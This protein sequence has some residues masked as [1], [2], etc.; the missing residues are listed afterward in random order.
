MDW[1]V[2]RWYQKWYV[3]RPSWL[4][5]HEKSCIAV[6]LLL[7][8]RTRYMF[9][10][11]ATVLNLCCH[12]I[13]KNSETISPSGF[14]NDWKTISE[15]SC[16]VFLWSLQKGKPMQKHITRD[17]FTP[18]YTNQ[19]CKTA[20]SSHSGQNITH[21]IK[22]CV[23]SRYMSR[24]TKQIVLHIKGRRFRPSYFNNRYSFT[25]QRT[26]LYCESPLG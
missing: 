2:C 16:I 3:F 19:G 14:N 6:I 25:G 18:A 7:T 5:N 23:L 22:Y 13:L 8:N 21:V 1:K 12:K 9:Q 15:N 20:H 11:A 4:S 26:S 24:F 10:H 17:L